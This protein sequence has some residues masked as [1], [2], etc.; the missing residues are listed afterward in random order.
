MSDHFV[1]PTCRMG[2]LDLRLTT[3]VRQYGE[4]LISVPNTPAWVC[5]V[6]QERHFD[7]SSVQRIELLI[8]QAGPP[9]NRYRP[10]PKVKRPSEA[11][12]PVVGS[13]GKSQKV[14]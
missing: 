8:G 5:D 2:H 10:A 3:Y 11:A 6:C 1:C 13:A 14:K 4:T 9:P 12:T 7:P